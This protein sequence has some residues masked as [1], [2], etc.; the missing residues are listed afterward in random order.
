MRTQKEGALLRVAKS[1][2]V[3]SPFK[4]NLVRYR[5]PVDPIGLTRP[6]QTR[7]LREIYSQCVIG[8]AYDTKWIEGQFY[9]EFEIPNVAQMTFSERAE[10]KQYLENRKE[11]IL[12]EAEERK[13]TVK[14]QM[15]AA[16]QERQNLMDK[17]NQF[18][19]WLKTQKTA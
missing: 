4:G 3:T 1:H 16:A 18:E 2:I 8:G 15:E 19:E 17:M 6:N 5:E 11:Q 14:K 12:A 9:G 10:Y 13:G 7:T